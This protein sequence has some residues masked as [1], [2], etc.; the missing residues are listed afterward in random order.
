MKCQSINQTQ[1][2]LNLIT[3]GLL[4]NSD[5]VWRGRS[6]EAVSYPAAGNNRCF[7]L[8]DQSFWF[9]HRNACL[10]TVFREF[11]TAG[12]FFDIGGGNGFVAAALQAEGKAPVVLIEPGAD[13]IR[14]AQTR[15]IGT[16]VQAT[17]KEARFRDRSL[18]AI[19]F[20]TCWSMSK[21]SRNFCV[22]S[23]VASLR[24]DA[25]T[26]PCRR[27]DG[28]G[29]MPMCRPGIFA[30]TH[31]QVCGGHWGAPGSEFYS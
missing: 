12:P 14:H 22:K 7:A 8:E 3:D 19:G 28:Y 27:G 9:A 25:S 4:Q 24:P 18:P 6:A 17:L 26:L 23:A 2:D 16:V 31:S 5:G 1:I 20:L 21:M 11:S 29:R 15:G 10:V 30:A 13:G